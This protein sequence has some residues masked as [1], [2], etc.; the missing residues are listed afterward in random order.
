M[1]TRTKYLL[2]L[3]D[4]VSN[5]FELLNTI[6][7]CFFAKWRFNEYGQRNSSDVFYRVSLWAALKS[8]EIVFKI[9]KN[10]E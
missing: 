10:K 4:L 2:A 3:L 1:K 7:N 5:L 8:M 9:N 6:L